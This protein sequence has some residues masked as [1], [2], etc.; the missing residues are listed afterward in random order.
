MNVLLDPVFIEVG[1]LGGA[2]ALLY[3]RS[4]L[5][6]RAQIAKA[7]DLIGNITSLSMSSADATRDRL[8]RIERRL[9]MSSGAEGAKDIMGLLEELRGS[10]RQ[11]GC[12]LFLGTYEQG[13]HG[14]PGERRQV[15]FMAGE[16]VELDRHGEAYVETGTIQH[17]LV[18]GT[19][20]IGLGGVVVADVMAG[21]QMFGAWSGTRATGAPVA[22]IPERLE[23]GTQI[24]VRV[25]R[26]L[27]W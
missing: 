26:G 10:G 14:A 20:V 21:A 8:E 19:I 2:G 25:V 9:G 23:V 17:P 1:I 24:R 5:E 11:R 16:L 4:A 6:R 3:L 22:L 18:P 27:S 7:D 13:A 15:Q 12:V